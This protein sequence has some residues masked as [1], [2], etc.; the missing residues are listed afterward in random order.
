MS[1]LEKLSPL[2]FL[3]M[4]S[5]GAIFVKLGLEDA[6]VW[7]F[8]AI[9][10]AGAALA[11]ALACAILTKLFGR[12]DVLKL[13]PSKVLQAFA[14]GF[15]LQVS[16]QA[17]F[18]LALDYQLSPGLLAI[19]LGLQP[20]L[21]P[22]FAR[23]GVG[24]KGYV[25]LVF[26]LIGLSI[27]VMGAREVGTLTGMGLVFGML[28]VLAISI[29]TV[30]QKRVDIQP[31]ASA[32]YQSVCASLVFFAI[33]PFAPLRL[34]LTPQ[35]IVS[36]A[37]MIFVVSTFAVLLLFFMLSRAAASKV[38]ILF[39]LVPVVTII[40]DYVFFEASVSEVTVLG[41]ALVIFSVI[42][43]NQISRKKDQKFSPEKYKC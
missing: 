34:E 17:S 13:P 39:Y 32:F 18:F 33:L 40:L 25:V 15:L 26:G 22:I 41:T 11:L 1:A 21:T 6:S 38:S 23:D 43:F 3:L 35:F 31:L 12:V 4:W 29:G 20:I 24:A 7:V 27:A 37:W 2:L 5:S 14:I 16:Y 36:A 30:L 28:S 42:I 10:S 9:R 8:L 19:I